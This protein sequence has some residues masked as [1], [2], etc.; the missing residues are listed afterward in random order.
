MEKYYFSIT[1]YLEDEQEWAIWIGKVLDPPYAT[2]DLRHYF[3]KPGSP[4]ARRCARLL[5]KIAESEA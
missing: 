5:A 3:R 1:K 2:D 4:S